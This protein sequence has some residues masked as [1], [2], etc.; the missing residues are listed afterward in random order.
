MKMKWNMFGFFPIIDSIHEVAQGENSK[1]LLHVLKT[2]YSNGQLKIK[3]NSFYEHERVLLTTPLCLVL[4]QKLKNLTALRYLLAFGANPNLN[5]QFPISGHSGNAPIHEAARKDNLEAITMLVLAGADIYQLGS[6]GVD[7]RTLLERRGYSKKDFSFLLMRLNQIQKDF[8]VGRELIEN[9]KMAQ[10]DRMEKTIVAYENLIL[11]WETCKY[12]DFLSQFNDHSRACLLA[13]MEDN[14]T[15]LKYDLYEF[16]IDQ[17]YDPSSLSDELINKIQD[18]L[19]SI[20]EYNKLDEL[21]IPRE[22]LAAHLANLIIKPETPLR[23]KVNSL[24]SDASVEEDFTQSSYLRKR[25]VLV[26]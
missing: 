12:E 5:E 25:N 2:L 14:I 23:K 7:L 6:G 24:Y 9:S 22:K 13:F 16:I 17:F 20:L 11:K 3:I 21:P 1:A 26:I 15:L 18:L 8:K 10:K 19:S 4:N